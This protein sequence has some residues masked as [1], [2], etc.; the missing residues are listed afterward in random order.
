MLRR[1]LCISLVGLLLSQV[2]A[3]P[4]Y[5]AAK[6]DDERIRKIKEDVHQLSQT[7]ESHVRIELRDHRK[8]KGYIAKVEDDQ[9]VI[10][11]LK[12]GKSTTVLYSDVLKVKRIKS[13]AGLV[14]A[15][16]IIGTL[17]GIFVIVLV[18]VPRD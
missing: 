9:F 11:D 7:G 3:S 10:S 15:I 14:K 4:V 16:G 17:V 18:S 12:S 8:L 13:H 1:S 6:Q 2:V 5:P